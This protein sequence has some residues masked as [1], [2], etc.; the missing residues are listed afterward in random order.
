MSDLRADALANELV[1]V[2]ERLAREAADLLLGAIAASGPAGIVALA[3]KSTPTDH[4]TEWDHASEQL[5]VSRLQELRPDDAVM[6]EEG[7]DRP[8]TSGVRWIID[9]IDGTT[10]FL[11][12]LPPF[13]VS[14]AAELDGEVIAGAVADPLHGEL[15]S[16]AR[17]DGARRNGVPISV[18]ARADLDLA[19]VAT[20]FS[21]DGDRR[22]RQAEVLARVLPLVRDMRRGGA[23]SID[24]CWVACGRVDGYWEK[25]LG[26][27]DFSA[28][29][30]IAAEA[31]AVLDDLAG[32][33]PSTS[34]VFAAAPRIAD[35]LRSL[36]QEA[37][38]AEV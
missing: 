2:A 30:L 5:I 36:L 6:G 14:I 35:S 7:S 26:P 17:G 27:W 18:S 12:G 23:A 22:R 10:N 34:F 15:Y 11:Y 32:G 8:G 31:G 13:G 28:G 33:P 16:A 20:G 21:Y 37:G 38:A 9:P 25:S 29:A 1:G 3:D 19:L 4:V 24:L